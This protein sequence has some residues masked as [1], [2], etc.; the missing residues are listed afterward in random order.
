MPPF[1]PG[2]PGAL[3][4]KVGA[5]SGA[6]AVALGAFGAHG[7][8]KRVNDPK[9]LAT[10]STAASYHLVHSVAL[11]VASSQRSRVPGA[12]FAAGIGLFSGSLYLLVLTGERRL[13]A[14]TPL[15][16]LCFIGGWLA[17]LL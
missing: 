14:V 7:L 1:F 3:W 13:G 12:L 9:L 16:G 11:L 4:W 15:G 5:V 10:W 17:L 8:Q 6:A 2:V